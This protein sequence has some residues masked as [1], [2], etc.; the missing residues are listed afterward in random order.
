MSD[1]SNLWVVEW[2]EIQKAFH[3]QT[4]ADMLRVNLGLFA[5][6]LHNGYVPVGIF[7]EYSEAIDFCLQMQDRAKIRDDCEA[8][9]E[10]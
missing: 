7:A 1:V 4:T 3:I 2:S 6:R 9:N 5:R 10:G 8:G